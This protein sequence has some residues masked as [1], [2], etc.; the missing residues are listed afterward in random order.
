ME[1]GGQ[2]NSNP[3]WQGEFSRIRCWKK[4]R[5]ENGKPYNKGRLS[6]L[7]SQELQ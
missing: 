4:V 5:I 3:I 7:E 1:T 6:I 2:R